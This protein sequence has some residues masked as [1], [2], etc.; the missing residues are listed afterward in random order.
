[1]FFRVVDLAV[2]LNCNPNKLLPPI[3]MLLE[4]PVLDTLKE[5]ANF[6]LLLKMGYEYFHRTQL[7]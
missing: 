1:M 6:E 2:A 5:N 7:L 4:D 3:N